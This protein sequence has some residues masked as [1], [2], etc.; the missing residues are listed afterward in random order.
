M[1][2]YKYH[3]LYGQLF[4]RSLLT[5]T[6]TTRVPACKTSNH[7]CSCLTF[8][9]FSPLSCLG[10][11]NH[12]G[13]GP[14]GR[15]WGL[16]SSTKFSYQSQPSLEPQ[17]QTSSEVPDIPSTITPVKRKALE[18][19]VGNAHLSDLNNAPGMLDGLPSLRTTSQGGA[20]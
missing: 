11:R 12:L 19:A 1:L 6:I 20:L 3:V 7:F 13:E 18:T 5:H 8:P 9:R 16:P 4:T 2:Y 17:P 10:R 14:S 15:T